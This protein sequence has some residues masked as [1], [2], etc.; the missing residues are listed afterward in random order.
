VSDNQPAAMPEKQSSFGCLKILI[1]MAAF[2]AVVLLIFGILVWNTIAWFQNSPEPKMASYPPLQ[3]S[4]GEKE[5]VSRIITELG[6]ATQSGTDVDEYVT[7]QVFNGVL[8]KIM[9]DERKK[10]TAKADA[11]LNFRAAVVSNGFEVKVTVPYTD[12]STKQVMQNMYVNIDVVGDIEI[13]NGHIA[14][15]NISKLTLKDEQAPLLARMFY[16]RITEALKADQEKKAEF[17]P[18]KTLKREGER[19]HFV[20]DGKKLKEQEDRKKANVNQP[21]PTP[22]TPKT[23]EADD[24]KK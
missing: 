2:V 18:I 11:P 15:L 13:A 12:Q 19:V 24:E 6:T 9:E 10:K 21:A 8:E 23:E 17:G 4:A 20:L 22:A 14:E 1:I 7:A 3:L 16:G 5:D